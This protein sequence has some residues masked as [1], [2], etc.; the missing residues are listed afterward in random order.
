VIV[1]RFLMSRAVSRSIHHGCVGRDG[2]RATD[3]CQTFACLLIRRISRLLRPLIWIA[4]GLAAAFCAGRLSVLCGDFVAS[5][6]AG[7]G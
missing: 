7:R 1:I 3:L 2:M 5:N 6:V 4:A